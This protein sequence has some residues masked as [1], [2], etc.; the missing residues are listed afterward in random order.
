MIDFAVAHFHML[1]A[2]GGGADVGIARAAK[3]GEDLFELL[4]Q[5]ARM[6]TP[7]EDTSLAYPYA[8]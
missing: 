3:G 8:G 7:V 2:R 4:A 6:I 1:L 5:A